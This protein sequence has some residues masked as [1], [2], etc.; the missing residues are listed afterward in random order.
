MRKIFCAALAVMLMSS[1]GFA[2]VNVNEFADGVRLHSFGT[3]DNM[4]DYCYIVE[5]PEGLVMIESTAYRPT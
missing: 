5:S 2:A 1:A 3:G 4:N